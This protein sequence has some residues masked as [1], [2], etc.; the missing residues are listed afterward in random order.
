MG[1]GV[2]KTRVGSFKGTGAIVTVTGVEFRPRAIR[3]INTD[4][5]A[6]GDWVQGMPDDSVVKAVTAG[7]ISNPTSDGVIPLS[8]GFSLGTDADLNVDG[9]RVYWV[10]HESRGLIVEPGSSDPG[11]FGSL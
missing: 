3:L 8:D 1:S 9:E 6:T 4:G 10:A 2:S 5:L 11:S 7:T